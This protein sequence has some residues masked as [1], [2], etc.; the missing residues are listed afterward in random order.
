MKKIKFKD[1]V[2]YCLLKDEGNSL[3]IE[4]P[5]EE[6]AWW[7]NP[8]RG[9][10]DGIWYIHKDVSSKRD[11]FTY[12]ILTSRNNYGKFNDTNDS[13]LA[14]LP[15]H[16][17]NIPIEKLATTLWNIPANVKIIGPKNY[18]TNKKKPIY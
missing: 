4:G 14:M 13:V 16:F 9:A 15:H 5:K 3:I 17:R 10:A 6:F 11:R 8:F 12:I 18:L 1:Y 2:T 7:R